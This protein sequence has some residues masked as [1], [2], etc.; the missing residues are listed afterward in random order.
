MQTTLSAAFGVDSPRNVFET[1]DDSAC[2][3]SR[4]STGSSKVVECHLKIRGLPVFI[5]LWACRESSPP[6]CPIPRVTDVPLL[7]SNLQKA[8]RRR[9][10]A[11]AATTALELAHVDLVTLARRL[12]IITI[13]DVRPNAHVCKCV[14]IAVAL[15][16][17]GYAA[18]RADAIWLVQYAQALAQDSI[19]EEPTETT[20]VDSIARVWRL[21]NERGD[22]TALALLVRVAFGGM[23][24]DMDMLV[25]AANRVETIGYPEYAPWPMDDVARMT[26]ENV[27]PAAIDFHCDSTLLKELSARSGHSEGDIKYAIWNCSSKANARGVPADAKT[28]IFDAISAHMEELRTARIRRAFRSVNPHAMPLM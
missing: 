3:V 21:A 20:R 27:I 7:V 22:S 17:R 1:S 5:E 28:P 8:I 25:R 11:I 12:V 19:R 26:I 15:Q 14:W 10:V 18:T 13:E 24:G 2:F 16:S 4:S 9:L 6:F 23:T